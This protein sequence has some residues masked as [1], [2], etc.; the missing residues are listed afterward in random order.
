MINSGG[1]LLLPISKTKIY[2]WILLGI[3]SFVFFEYFVQERRREREREREKHVRSEN[4]VIFILLLSIIR[5]DIFFLIPER[6][7]NAY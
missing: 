3:E 6:V 4:S 7:L 2:S 5:Q 1:G